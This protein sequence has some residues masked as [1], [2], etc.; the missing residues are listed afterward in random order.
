MNSDRIMNR[1]NDND[2]ITID[3]AE[4]FFVLWS[5][6]HVILLTGI[7]LALVSFVGTKLLVT[8]KSVSY[9][10]LTLPTNSRV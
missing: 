1:E 8:P 9:T 6:I 4:L 2:E 7:L 10:H 3:L 5:K